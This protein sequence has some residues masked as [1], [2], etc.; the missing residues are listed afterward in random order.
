MALSFSNSSM[1]DD[2][3]HAED[4]S[5]VWLVFVP[6]VVGL[7]I[8]ITVV[9]NAMVIVAYWIDSCIHDRAANLLILN[10]AISDFI[11]GLVV[12]SI[13]LSWISWN[14]WLGGDYWLLGETFCKIWLVVDYTACMM[15]VLM[16]I[17]ISL[18]R[19]WLLT[20]K[21]GYFR[22]Q[23]KRRLSVTISVLWIVVTTVYSV[24]AFGWTALT[25]EAE[26]DFTEEC[27]MDMTYNVY[28]TFVQL[29]LEFVF[30]L[31]LI[32]ILNIIVYHKIKLRAQGRVEWRTDGPA[33][34]ATAQNQ[35]RMR[36]Y[37]RHRRAAVV[38]AVLVSVFILCWLPYQIISVV[39]ALCGDQCVSYTAW[40]VV[41]NL[42]WCNST[43]NPFLYAA[44]NV[45]FRRNF[46]NFLR[47]EKFR[48]FQPT[49]E[50][51]A[52]RSS[53]GADRQDHD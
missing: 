7:I 16:I 33:Q 24:V 37:A 8:V 29:I 11:V 38:L 27:E 20:M 22:F 45:H 42:L 53:T 31:S 47:L 1:G 28:A 46:V 40:E 44:T 2:D 32:S 50:S 14:E 17:L 26:V 3:V 6:V 10:L 48:C 30:P 5:L 19:Y 9:G 51:A 23:T 12:L 49:T 25:G 34:L 4:P 15:S 35:E 41:N 43:I 52:T 13:N 21:L 39:S 36:E 18:D